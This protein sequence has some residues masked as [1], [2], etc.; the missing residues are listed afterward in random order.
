M[1]VNIQTI[2][3]IR[4]FLT[5]ELA[6]IYPDTETGAFANIIIRKLARTPGMHI[7]G[8]PESHL[9]QKQVAQILSIC[10]ELKTGKPLQYVMGETSFY[11]CTIKVNGETLIPRP[12][13]EELVDLIVKE[14]RGFR[15]TI[16]DMGTG[17]GC[18][19]IALALNLP[20]TT[21]TGIDISE[22]AIAL[23]R[24]N[25]KLNDADVTFLKADIMN[26]DSNQFIKTDIIV[27]NPPYVRESEKKDMDHNVL[28]F[29][30]HS[31]LFVPDSDPLRYYSAILRSAGSIL[32]PG[33]KVYFEINEAMGPE[34]SHLIRKH[35]YTEIG[36]IKD[37]NDRNRIVKGTRNG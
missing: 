35:G 29:E 23:A 17:S 11:N 32:S 26:F 1:S 2:K 36:L 6:G 22:G 15:G 21:V 25:S 7:S 9:T 16:L 24:K 33:G 12:E 19:A 10:R 28:D 27:S 37:L 18:I 4:P 13:T 8:L 5:R 31:A 14:N 3:D 30:P 34:L 20:G